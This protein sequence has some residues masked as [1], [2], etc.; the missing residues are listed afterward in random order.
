M[1]R[2]QRMVAA[3]C[4]D[5]R[6]VL[7]LVGKRYEA[8]EPVRRPL[9]QPCVCLP[10]HPAGVIDVRPEQKEVTGEATGLGEQLLLQPA[11]DGRA[12]GS[13]SWLLLLQ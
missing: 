6:A 3:H 12:I 7:Q 1:L 4:I 8:I 13:C 2:I 5:E 10:S 11:C 9:M